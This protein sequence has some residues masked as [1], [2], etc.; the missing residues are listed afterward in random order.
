MNIVGSGGGGK[1]GGG[2]RVAVEAPNTLQSVQKAQIIDLISEGPIVGLVDGPESVFLNGVPLRNSDGSNNFTGYAYEF[3]VGTATQTPVSGALGGVKRTLVNPSSGTEIKKELPQE[4][5]ISDN[6]VE[7]VEIT[8]GLPQLTYQDPQT[9]DLNGSRVDY[10]IYVRGNTSAYKLVKASY[11][12]GKC[13]SLYQRSY[14]ID[15]E[16]LE[17]PVYIRVERTTEDSTKVNTQNKIYWYTYTEIIPAKLAYPYCALVNFAI[18]AEQFQ[19][20]PQRGYEIYGLMIKVPSNYDPAKR[21]YTGSWDGTFKTAWTDNPAWVYYDLVTNTRYGLGDLVSSSQ[22][23]KWDLY[24]I[25]KYCD[26]LVPTGFGGR[27][28]RFT[29]NTYIQSAD[30]AYNVLNSIA[31]IFRG[32]QFWAAS[33]ISVSAD[34]PKDPIAQFTPANVIDGTFVYSGTSAKTRRT[35]ALVTWNDPKDMYRQKVE[36]VEDFDAVQK[37]GVIAAEVV[38]VGCTSQGQA[39]RVGRWLLYSEQMETETI[40]FTTSL[41]AAV[42]FPGEIIQTSDPFRA[43][44][45]YGGRILASSTTELELDDAS[46]I[47]GVVN[48]STFEPYYDSTTKTNRAK[49][50]TKSGTHLNGKFTPSTAYTVAPELNSVWVASDLNDLEPEQW[51]VLS[52]TENEDLT[53]TVTGLEYRKDKFLAVE[54]GLTLEE[55]PTTLLDYKMPETP[56]IPPENEATWL[57]EYLYF[58][59]P[60]VLNNGVTLSWTSSATTFI[61][62]YKGPDSIWRQRRVEEPFLDL[63]PL[64]IGTYTFEIVAVNTL[65]YKSN[66]LSRTKT[67][68]GKM[69]PPA[70]VLDFICQKTNAG[71][72]LKWTKNE[73]LDLK[74]YEI[75]ELY[76][77]PTGTLL[78]ASGQIV[79]NTAIITDTLK[80]QIWDSASKSSSGVIYETNYLDPQ[81]PLG[82]NLYLVKAV[83]TSGNYSTVP[84]IAGVRVT[85]PNPVS[86]TS[87]KLDGDQIVIT[88]PVPTSDLGIKHYEVKYDNITTITDKAEFRGKVWWSGATEYFEIVAVDNGGNKSTTY[89]F[90]INFGTLG[91]PSSVSVSFEGQLFRL[92]WGA[93]A[94][95]SVLPV[96]EYEIRTNLNWGL[97]DAGLIAKV[98]GTTY[99]AVV[100]WGGN[101]RFYLAARDTANNIGSYYTID[102][103]VVLPSEPLGFRQTVVDNNVLLY[104]N[105]PI[106]GTLPVIEYEV[107][108]GSTWASATSIGTKSGKFTTI[109]ETVAGDYSYWIAAIDSAGN[110]GPATKTTAKVNQPPDYI[111]QSDYYSTYSGTKSNAI[112]D[113]LTNYLVLPVNTAETWEGHYTSRTWSTPQDQITAG[114]PV[115][116][117]PSPTSGYYEETMNYTPDATLIPAS[118][119]TVGPTYRVVA[120]APTIACQ[121]SYSADGTTWTGPISG[122]SLF[123]S[124]FKYIKIR[125]TVTG[126]LIELTSLNYRLDT[127]LKNFMGNTTCLSTDTGGTTVYLTADK[128]S[129]G[130]K[131]FL[132][133]DSITLTPKVITGTVPVAIY[134]FVDSINPLSFK[135]LLFD[136]QTGARVSGT[137]SYSIRG[138]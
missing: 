113:N 80:N 118:T 38:A 12:E 82:Y 97:D 21:T 138:Y 105:D 76:S 92:N 66:I 90:Q 60:G 133:V 9:G 72:L 101:K 102:V 44:K 64:P 49:L 86:S 6:R 58:S 52:I 79:W 94:A 99:S 22:I 54:R 55:R 8:I 137:C 47:N 120:G 67:I 128:T 46:L 24:T 136:S 41:E 112:I 16:G 73:D 4:V 115:Y 69:A 93:P 35:V 27:E 127:K 123:V 122:F 121:I 125:V 7:T 62:R 126:G 20:V 91:A 134:D 98:T 43:G 109:M 29:C 111:L 11:M 56:Y 88:W 70:D 23:N 34:M 87:W 33:Q 1:G 103:P 131:V 95:A 39:N 57:Q 107:R 124:N 130:D 3:R 106:Q 26:E 14:S 110:Y 84:S 37:Y 40:T 119:I 85:V 42:V 10:K 25:A 63:R 61:I 89:N 15:I 45:R 51:R 114:Y 18:D 48:L 96:Q 5:V 53:V 74:G 36:Y 2:G 17:F 65:G 59:G 71:L 117:Q 132:D 108:K 83:D 75:R 31:S 81:S 50:V 19:Q 100:D 32:M 135:I 68:L 77:L 13:T 78:N 28:P 104:W 30:Q 129:T 116:I